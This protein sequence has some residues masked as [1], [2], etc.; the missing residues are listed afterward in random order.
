MKIVQSIEDFMKRNFNDEI[1]DVQPIA[2]M[3]IKYRDIGERLEGYVVPVTYKNRGQ[4]K[5]YFTIDNDHWKIV[6]AEKAFQNAKDYHLKSSRKMYKNLSG[7]DDKAFLEI[8]ID[9]KMPTPIYNA[10]GHIKEYRVSVKYHINKM[11]IYGQNGRTFDTE[12]ANAENWIE[13]L[14]SRGYLLDGAPKYVKSDETN[15]FNVYMSCGRDYCF[16][17]TFLTAAKNSWNFWLQK[18][19]DVSKVKNSQ[20]LVRIINENTK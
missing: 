5:E 9:I 19:Y 17:N 12:K 13:Y 3:R 7:T 6:S 18:Q 15:S 20:E 14:K 1:I 10:K 8:P 4:S 16:T 11:F 2:E